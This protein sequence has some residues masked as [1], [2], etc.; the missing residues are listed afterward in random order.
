MRI[1]KKTIDEIFS[2]AVIEE[3]ISDFVVLKKTGANYKGLSPFNDE[4]T[5][6]F[7][8]SPSKEIWKDFSSGRGG[9]LISFLMEHEQYTYPEALLFLAKKYNITVEYI[10]LDSHEKKK[11]TEREA[12]LLVLNF[13]KTVFLK[14]LISVKNKA[15]DYLKSRGFLDSIIK[16]FEIGYCP[17]GD[18]ELVHAAK[19]AG[20]NLEYLKKTRIINEKDQNRFS[21]RLIFPIHSISGQVLGFGGRVLDNQQKTVKYLNSDSSEIYQKSK[22]LYGMHL[23]KRYIKT[24]DSC[25]IVEGY[26]DVLALHQIG[27]KNVVSNCGTALTK[28]QIRL[29]KRFTNTIIILFDSDLAGVNATL[30]AIDAILKQSMVPKVL[31]LPSGEDPASFTR[32]MSTD[33]MNLYIQ[34]NIVDFIQFKYNLSS[35]LDTEGLIELTKS[36]I[37]SIVLIEDKI[38]QTFHIRHAAKLLNIKEDDLVISLNKTKID[39]DKYLNKNKKLSNNILDKDSNLNFEKIKKNALEEFQLIRLLIDHG[40]SIISNTPVKT[41]VLDFIIR[42][43]DQDSIQFQ[44]PIFNDIFNEL[45]SNLKSLNFFTKDYFLT[46]TNIQIKNLSSYI[47][48]EQHF[49][50]NWG[51]KDIVVLEE[52]DILMKVTKE[53]ILRFKLKRV[54]Q[55]VKE[56]LVNLKQVSVDN[57]GHLLQR[58][59]GLNKLEKKIQQE[60]GRLV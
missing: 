26:T 43:L 22:V 12:T 17:S 28:D 57:E 1:S 19:K 55:M 5:P 32:L 39:R 18:K 50:G 27:I 25:Y 44:V 23:A 6:S 24:T 36:I 16:E 52:K 53:A 38:S 7:V 21:G 37:S 20:Y 40:N 9:N 41:R 46:H 11:E 10:E 8:V 42:E 45:K 60:L 56:S 14:N 13:A 30:K 15:I 48:G 31:Q 58:F 49:L 59:T 2:T 51:N 33:D 35:N 29:I 4:K 54:Q 3:V 34:K 47:V